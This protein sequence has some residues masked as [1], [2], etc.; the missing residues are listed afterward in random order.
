MVI[1]HWSS[2]YAL[3]AT[4]LTNGRRRDHGHSNRLGQG[5]G[6]LPPPSRTPSG[7]DPVSATAFSGSAASGRT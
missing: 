2:S 4:A 7:T 6:I 3:G 5:D 1:T